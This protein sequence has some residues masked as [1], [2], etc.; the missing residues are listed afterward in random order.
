MKRTR[1]QI[2]SNLYVSNWK[3]SYDVDNE[4]ARYIA[5]VKLKTIISLWNYRFYLNRKILKFTAIYIIMHDICNEPYIILHSEYKKYPNTQAWINALCG[6]SRIIFN[7]RECKST[8]SA[9]TIFTLEFGIL[10]REYIKA[11]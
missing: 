6:Y 8:C 3:S 11:E 2:T 7:I 9:I 10:F 4:M 1:S 5:R